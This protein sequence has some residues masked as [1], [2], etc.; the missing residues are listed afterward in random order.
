MKNIKQKIIAS[1]LEQ[2]LSIKNGVVIVDEISC[3]GCGSCVESCPHSAIQIK[4]LSE[5]E[6]K[7]LPFRGR[8]K[9]MAK[10]PN[11]AHINPDICTACGF[12]MKQC[13]EFA[14][15]KSPLIGA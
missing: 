13:H 4:T 2:E 10:G 6:I 9:V 3:D 15:H 7:K 8:L 1:K 11:K 14:I 12:C 5:E